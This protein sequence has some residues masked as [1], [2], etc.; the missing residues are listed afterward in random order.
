EVLDSVVTLIME[1]S[2]VHLVAAG[3]SIPTAMDFGFR[4]GRIGIRASCNTIIENSLNE[5]TLGRPD[6]ILIVISHSGSSKRV[7]NALELAGS[8]GMKSVILTHSSR[9]SAALLADYCLLTYPATPLFQNYG[10]ASHLFDTVMVDLILY[11]ITCRQHRD[12]MPD[13]LEMLLSEYKV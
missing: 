4:L 11:L 10:I 5:I 8:R 9:N 13:Q 12:D 6:E 2:H 1:S 7:I 3:N